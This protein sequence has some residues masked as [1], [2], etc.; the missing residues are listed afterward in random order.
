MK[1]NKERIQEELKRL[2]WTRYRLSQIM[3]VTPGTV[4]TNL[5]KGSFKTV[6]K[7]ARA[8]GVEETDL[9]ING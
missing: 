9:V 7:L 5:D 2:G 1:I 3:G 6:E 4:Y 8:L